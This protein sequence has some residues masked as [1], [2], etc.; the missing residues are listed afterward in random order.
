MIGGGSIR[1][2][3]EK[4]SGGISLDDFKKGVGGGK[5]ENEQ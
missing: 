2:D 1:G 4:E 5:P 3:E